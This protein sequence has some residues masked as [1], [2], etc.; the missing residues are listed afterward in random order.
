MKDVLASFAG[1]ASKWK[2]EMKKDYNLFLFLTPFSSGMHES[3]PTA[4]R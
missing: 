3:L 4:S 2:N 1:S